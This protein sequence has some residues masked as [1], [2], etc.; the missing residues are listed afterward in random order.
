VTERYAARTGADLAGLPWYEAFACWKIAIILQQLHQRY[1]RGETTDERMATRGE[2]VAMLARR[3]AR[4][5]G[6]P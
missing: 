2:P 4:I 5:L 1:V 6:L 3:A